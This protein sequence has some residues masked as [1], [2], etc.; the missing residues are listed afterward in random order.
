LLEGKPTPRPGQEPQVQYW[1]VSSEYFRTTGIPLREGRAFTDRDDDE[2]HGVAIV[3]AGMAQRFWPGQS[4]LG[5]R[6]RL[7]IPDTGHY[8]LP[9]SRNQW[10]TVVGVAGDVKLAAIK[11]HPLPQMYLPYAQNPSAIFHLILRTAGNPLQWLP[12][13]RQTVTSLDKDQPVF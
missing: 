5:R 12:A 11:A 13:L 6:L 8:W 3:S 4:A 9:K 10:L 7:L 2:T 1:V